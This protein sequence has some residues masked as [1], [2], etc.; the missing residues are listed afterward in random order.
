MS[1]NK[2]LRGCILYEPHR[3][4]E[5]ASQLDLSIFLCT[6]K[7]VKPLKQADGCETDSRGFDLSKD[8]W[9]FKVTLNADT[10]LRSC[11]RNVDQTHLCSPVQISAFHRHSS[12]FPHLHSIRPPLCSLLHIPPML[13]SKT[14]KTHTEIV[15]RII[16]NC[17]LWNQLK[18]NQ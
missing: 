11:S 13:R 6:I 14:G 1:I 8:E 18:I 12:A 15:G 9:H 17:C 5:K 10:D 7:R 4:G 2:H 16:R 3:V